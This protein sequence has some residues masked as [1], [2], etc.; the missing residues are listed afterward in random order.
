MASPLRTA[1][2]RV[3]FLFG[4]TPPYPNQL[5]KCSSFWQLKIFPISRNSKATSNFFCWVLF[6][7]M[8]G[9]DWMS[10]PAHCASSFCNC[11]WLSYQ[12]GQQP[13]S[14]FL[15]FQDKGHL[16]ASVSYD[17]R[18]LLLSSMSGLAIETRLEVRSRH[19]PLSCI[20]HPILSKWSFKNPLNFYILMRVSCLTDSWSPALNFLH[21]GLFLNSLWHL[22]AWSFG[23]NFP[24]NI[25]FIMKTN[26]NYLTHSLCQALCKTLYKCSLMES[27]QCLELDFIIIMFLL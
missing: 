5:D 27:S 22:T 4:G 20:S 2:H 17:C 24:L 8:K 1:K 6:I 14:Y 25:L 11:C 10:W 23:T 19:L 13:T 7:E 16:T 9:A 12:S 18:E 3:A 21:D 15:D 26:H